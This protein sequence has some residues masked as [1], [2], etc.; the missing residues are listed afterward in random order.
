MRVWKG[1]VYF[2]DC[3]NSAEDKRQ[4]ARADV[5]LELTPLPIQRDT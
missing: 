5:T 3:R 4:L 1:G 2:R